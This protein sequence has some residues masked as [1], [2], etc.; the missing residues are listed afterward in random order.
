MCQAHCFMDDICQS[1]NVSPQLDNGQWRCE[2]NDAGGLENLV[3]EDGQVYYFTKV[4][5][6]LFPWPLCLRSSAKEINVYDITTLFPAQVYSFSIIET[7]RLWK[8]T[9]DPGLLSEKIENVSS[10]K[11]STNGMA[12]FT[13]GSYLK[14][15]LHHRMRATHLRV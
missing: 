6:I 4:I 7:Q 12:N 10:I 8:R 5:E 11:P 15:S 13:P 1:I 2:L 9:F 3:D 14:C